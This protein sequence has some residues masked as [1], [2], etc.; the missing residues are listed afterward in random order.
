MAPAE[1]YKAAPLALSYPPRVGASE[2]Q[3]VVETGDALAGAAAA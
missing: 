1:L 2:R 3:G